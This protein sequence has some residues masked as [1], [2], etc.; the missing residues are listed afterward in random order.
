MR[1]READHS[2]EE[3]LRARFE[4]LDGDNSGLVDMHPVHPLRCATALSRSSSRCAVMD[5]FKQWDRD[6]S[7]SIDKMEFRRAI[8]GCGFDFFTDDAEIDAVFEDFDIDG[9]GSLDYKELNKNLRQGAGSVL[10]AS[11]APGAAGEIVMKA[12]TKHAIRKRDKGAKAK[13]GG[14]TIGGSVAK[15]TGFAVRSK[16]RAK[17]KAATRAAAPGALDADDD[18]VANADEEEAFDDGMRQ[19]AIDYQTH[20]KDQDGKLDFDEFCAL[21]RE[22]EMADHSEE[23]LRARFEALDGDNRSSTCTSTSATPR[24]WPPSRP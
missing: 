4:A 22:R 18:D 13:H 19:N 14:Y 17:A 6:E 3:E 23:E 12:T 16:A 1:E 15:P 8:R 10:D 9:N 24:R 21:V 2:E 20:D 5:L 7:G 11:L